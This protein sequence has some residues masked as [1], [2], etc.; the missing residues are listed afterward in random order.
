[1]LS[2]PTDYLVLTYDLDLLMAFEDRPR[3]PLQN[4][5]NNV[6]DYTTS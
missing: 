4:I 5:H 2:G 3:M 6:P 1:M